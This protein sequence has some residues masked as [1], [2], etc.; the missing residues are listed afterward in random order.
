VLVTYALANILQLAA[1]VNA[2]LGCVV[3]DVF[4]RRQSLGKVR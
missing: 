2:D 3:A 4:V 1:L